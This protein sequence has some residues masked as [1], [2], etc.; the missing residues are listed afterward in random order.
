MEITE[1]SKKAVIRSLAGEPLVEVPLI[2]KQGMEIN[3]F[4]NWKDEAEA[5]KVYI[6]AKEFFNQGDFDKYVARG[7]R[8]IRLFLE[9]IDGIELPDKDS[10][11]VAV[12]KN[13]GIEEKQ[14]QTA[15]EL[16]KA[17]SGE[18]EPEKAPDSVQLE[19][20]VAKIA[21]D[22]IPPEL[23]NEFNPMCGMDDVL[24]YKRF[25]TEK[26]EQIANA[27]AVV[28]KMEGA[29]SGFRTL[30]Y[31]YSAVSYTHLTLPTIA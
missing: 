7:P 26:N 13:L 11:L 5:E 22:Y 10:E 8:I 20:L 15:T 25:L 9:R 29:L 18:I 6:E 28:F 14:L 21:E 2:E 31:E 23:L 4:S 17:A 19:K 24:N 30:H 1:G 12:L 16:I 3:W 27:N